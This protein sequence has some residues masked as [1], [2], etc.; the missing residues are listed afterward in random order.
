M[1]V[2]KISDPNV[3]PAFDSRILDSEVHPYSPVKFL[4]SPQISE[5]SD[6]REVVKKRIEQKTKYKKTPGKQPK[7]T[8][9]KE[10]K[11]SDVYG[12]FFFP[13][14]NSYDKY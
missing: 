6:W 11:Y 4:S 5:K 7:T 13:L 14:L 8:K 9:T 12:Y 10:N 1:S 3:E 2:Q